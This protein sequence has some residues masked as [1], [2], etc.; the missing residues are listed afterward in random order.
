MFFVECVPSVTKRCS[1]NIKHSVFIRD[2]K[3]VEELFDVLFGGR[4][5]KNHVEDGEL[6]RPNMLT[7]MVVFFRTEVST[8]L[9]FSGM[10]TAWLGGRFRRLQHCNQ[11]GGQTNTFLDEVGQEERQ[12]EPHFYREGVDGMRFTGARM[13]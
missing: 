11:E 2:R 6:N 12:V 9:L 3:E 10:V 5:T 8:I 1:A 4:S 13:Q 7:W